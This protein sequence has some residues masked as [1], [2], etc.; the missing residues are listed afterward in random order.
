MVC[1]TEGGQLGL[2]QNALQQ[3]AVTIW[4]VHGFVFLK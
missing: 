2:E 1:L 4:N 3:A